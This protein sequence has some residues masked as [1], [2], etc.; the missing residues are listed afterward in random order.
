MRRLKEELVV[1]ASVSVL[2][3]TGQLDSR[4]PLTKNTCKYTRSIIDH[5]GGR[6]DWKRVYKSMV[7]P[8]AHARHGTPPQDDSTAQRTALCAIMWPY[9]HT[10]PSVER[11][12]W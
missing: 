4:P 1:E 5:R 11:L 6:R 2:L 8:T 3:L 10:K 7:V 9:S 12:G